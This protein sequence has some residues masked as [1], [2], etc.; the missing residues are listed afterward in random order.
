[1]ELDWNM[2]N[3]SEVTWGRDGPYKDPHCLKIY[4]DF[5]LP[6]YLDKVCV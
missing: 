5:P 3:V 4:G 1:M 2:F 6:R